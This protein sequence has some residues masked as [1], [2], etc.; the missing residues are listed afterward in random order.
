MTDRER[1][2]RAARGEWGDR[3]PVAPEAPTSQIAD[4]LGV[5]HHRIIP[6]FL[7]TR[8]PDDTVDRGLGIYRLRG[9]AYRAAL[10]GADPVPRGADGPPRVGRRPRARQRV[11]R[12][13]PHAGSRGR[14]AVLL[15]ARRPS[16]GGPA[17]L[18]GHGA[19]LRA[20]RANPRRL[21]RRGGDDGGPLRRHHHLP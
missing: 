21:A 17:A 2:L 10:T 9:L 8:T 4:D 7:K 14:H 12:A 6:E 20:A 19:L 1:M 5:A 3:L 13:A 18:R 15:R 11:A 16:Q